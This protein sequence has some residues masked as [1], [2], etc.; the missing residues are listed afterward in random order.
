[1]TTP[2]KTWMRDR[3]PSV[4]LTCTLRVSPGLKAGMSSRSWACSSSAIAVCM[5]DLPQSWSEMR[6]SA[7]PGVSLRLAREHPGGVKARKK[8]GQRSECS[9]DSVCHTFAVN[10][11][12]GLGDH[13]PVPL[14][15]AVAR[16][17][18]A[19]DQGRPVGGGG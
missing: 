11:E 4:T 1:M 9:R 8:R 15:E 6:G 7:H 14:V 3:L 13:L 16:G 19:A 2:W 5:M 10:R 17:R 12:T 18:Q